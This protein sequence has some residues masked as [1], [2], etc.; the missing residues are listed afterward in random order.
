ML[1]YIEKDSDAD[2]NDD[3]D[4]RQNSS[5][6]VGQKDDFWESDSDKNSIPCNCSITK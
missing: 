5:H 6:D 2:D 1:P 3:E 4:S